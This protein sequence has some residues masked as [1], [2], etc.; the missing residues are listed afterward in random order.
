M[1]RAKKVSIMSKPESS[2]HSGDRL[3]DR[4]FDW[5]DFKVQL[6]NTVLMYGPPTITLAQAEESML[7]LVGYLNQCV[8][9]NNDSTST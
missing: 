2:V 9:A 7:R 1:A 3:A 6:N 4:P 5:G 8:E